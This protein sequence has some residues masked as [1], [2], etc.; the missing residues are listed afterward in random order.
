MGFSRNREEP[1]LAVLACALGDTGEPG[2]AFS[3][4]SFTEIFFVT[5]WLETILALT[6]SI[7]A[8][9]PQ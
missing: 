4:L 9:R 6:M 2:L 3:Q 7:I 8:M 1:A 5:I